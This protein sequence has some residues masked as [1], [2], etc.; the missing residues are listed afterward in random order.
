MYAAFVES[1]VGSFMKMVMMMRSISMVRDFI[2]LSDRRTD[3]D[4]KT[5]T[6]KIKFCCHVI[7]IK[8]RELLGG[9]VKLV[10]MCKCP[11]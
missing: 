8:T 2:N 11:L 5:H 7:V 1:A 9:S 4:L 6:Q 10:C 3:G